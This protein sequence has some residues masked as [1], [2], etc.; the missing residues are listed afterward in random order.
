MQIE[1]A[2]GVFLHVASLPGPDGIGTLGDHARAFVDFLADADATYWQ[3]CPIGPTATALGNSPYAALSAFA[4]NPL[5]VDLDD[6]RERGW[7]TAADV[8]DR[9]AFPAERVD[10]D[11]VADYKRDRL[12]R[13]HERFRGR[14]GGEAGP[15]ADADAGSGRTAAGEGAGGDDPRADF[16]RF[17]AA[18]GDWLPDYALFAALRARHGGPWTDWPAPLRDREPTA[19]DRARADL[20]GDVAFHAFCQF[21]FARQWDRL[22]AY[23]AGRG[24]SLVGDV[25]LYVG[26]DSADVWTNR[27]LFQLDEAGEPTALAGVPDAPDEPFD[28]QNWGA[29]VYDWDHL[30][31]TGFDWWRRRLGN[32]LSRVDLVRID[33][34]RGLERYWA[35]P[36]GAD[37]PNDGEWRDVPSE[38]FF[39]ALEAEFGTLP[40]FAEDIGHVTAAVEALRRC[41]GLPSLRLLP[42]ADPCDPDHPHLPA[43]Y[44]TDCVAYTSTHDSDTAVGSHRAMD[45]ERRECFRETVGAPDP[46]GVHRTY[47]DAVWSSDAVLAVAPLQDVLGLGSEARYNVPGTAAGNWEWRVRREQLTDDAAA[48]LATLT[49]E[50]DR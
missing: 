50:H 20:A 34:F 29:P 12:R 5:F 35:I 38:A 10:Y 8:A 1:R 43:N 18:N 15:G 9:P 47:L 46:A 44:P 30:A 31:E 41:H 49:A 42:F 27:E 3:F 2:S 26:H 6:L 25:P 22:R 32:L 4:G 33:H 21:C 11:A 28:A 36:A 17:R 13:A 14:D 23:A 48:R 45:A 39:E 7:L 40:A 24:V 19:L 37:D 16:E